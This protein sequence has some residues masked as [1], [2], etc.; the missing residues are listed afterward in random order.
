MFFLLPTQV[1]LLQACHSP[2]VFS[3]SP[4]MVITFETQTK[5]QLLEH[6]QTPVRPEHTAD[7]TFLQTL[8][9]SQGA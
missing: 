5:S 7:T 6:I 9:P 4:D 1:E 2:Q 8:P 3:P